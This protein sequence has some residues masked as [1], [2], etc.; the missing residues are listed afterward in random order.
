[1]T[2]KTLRQSYPNGH[3]LALVSIEGVLYVVGPG[4][5]RDEDGHEFEPEDE[6]AAVAEYEAQ[7]VKLAETPN[8]RAQAAYDD[9][10]GTDNGYAPWQAMREW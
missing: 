6:A 10:H 3:H 7:R 9:A 4:D 8:H 5:D 1:M 2:R